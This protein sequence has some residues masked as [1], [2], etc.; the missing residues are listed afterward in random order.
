MYFHKPIL[1]TLFLGFEVNYYF[2]LFYF[3]FKLHPIYLFVWKMTWESIAAEELCT[4]HEELSNS[5]LLRPHKIC[6]CMLAFMKWNCVY[7]NLSWKHK[8]IDPFFHEMLKQS[9]SLYILWNM[10][11]KMFFFSIARK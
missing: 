3:S 1:D 7:Y 4:F 2:I 11:D 8:S 5:V 10:W 9:Y 6:V